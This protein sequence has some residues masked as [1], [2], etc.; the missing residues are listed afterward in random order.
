ML[1]RSTDGGL[2]W[3]Q[4]QVI[5]KWD[6]PPLENPNGNKLRKQGA[7]AATPA[8]KFT[9]NNQTL[10]PDA[11]GRIHLDLLHRIFPRILSR[12]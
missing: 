1:S 7:L 3:S 2:T 9:F 11:D 8:G 5:G 12:Q 10:I 4:P 6:G